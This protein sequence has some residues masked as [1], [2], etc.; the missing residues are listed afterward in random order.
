MYLV[1]FHL[2]CYIFRLNGLVCIHLIVILQEI[3]ASN[4]KDI[5][6][7]I[8]LQLQEMDNELE[9]MYL[10]DRKTE[11]MRMK[12]GRGEVVCGRNGQWCNPTNVE[13]YSKP[14]ACTERVGRRV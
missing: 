13:T 3:N 7:I 10:C 9:C 5:L 11:G 14:K 2:W 6:L 8:H 4:N 12:R 1:T